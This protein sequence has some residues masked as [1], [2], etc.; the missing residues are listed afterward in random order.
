MSATIS[1]KSSCSK[2]MTPCLSVERMLSTQLAELTRW[3]LS[4]VFILTL[5]HL[6][7][8]RLC[9][10][11]SQQMQHDAKRAGG[12]SI[13]PAPLPFTSTPVFFPSSP[14]THFQTQTPPP[15]PQSIFASTQEVMFVA[16]FVCVF[17]CASLC[18]QPFSCDPDS[19]PHRFFFFLFV[20]LNER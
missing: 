5:R 4:P 14:Q 17:V 2:M 10:F 7:V 11:W 3:G 15:N 19:D 18:E 1:S 9:P 20:F 8:I 6:N 12:N 16:A 13:P